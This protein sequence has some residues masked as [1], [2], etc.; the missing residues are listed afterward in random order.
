[1]SVNAAAA[2]PIAPGEQTLRVAVNVV[3]ELK[4]KTP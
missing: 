4:P 2:T 1:M 3:Y